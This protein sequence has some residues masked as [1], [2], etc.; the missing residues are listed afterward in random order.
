[1]TDDWPWKGLIDAAL[2]VDDT[3]PLVYELH[4]FI[5]YNVIKG[6]K[7]GHACVMHHYA[8]PVKTNNTFIKGMGEQFWGTN[9]MEEFALGVRKFR[10]YDYAY[11]AP[12]SWINYWPNFLEG[13]SHEQ[14][15]W[16]PNNHQDRVDGVDGW[17]ST[18]VKKVMEGLHPYLVVDTSK[19]LENPTEAIPIENSSE[20]SDQDNI[21]YTDSLQS[22][23]QLYKVFE[24]FNG[25]L[26]DGYFCLKW[27][28]SSNMG[29]IYEEGS[30]EPFFIKAGFH[31]PIRL[32]IKTPVN[33]SK[34]NL[35]VNSLKDGNI[36][37]SYKSNVLLNK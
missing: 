29:L 2:E 27:T 10:L 15:A 32:L 37:Y 1:M 36:V 6:N 9:K 28:L 14:H 33:I 4:N 34:C 19:M 18:V 26:S 20:N 5:N 30:S 24:V 13:M 35:Q 8:P 11:V 17:N 3:R 7:K 16:K 12:W 22:G 25:S 23:S 21:N 31:V